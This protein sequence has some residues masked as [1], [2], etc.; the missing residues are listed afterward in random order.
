MSVSCSACCQGASGQRTSGSQLP[1][2]DHPPGSLCPSVAHRNFTPSLEVGGLHG[3]G[4]VCSIPLGPRAVPYPEMGD[5][6]LLRLPGARLT[7]QKCWALPAYPELPER[8]Q[9]PTGSGWRVFSTRLGWS[10]KRSLW[11]DTK[12]AQRSVQE[13]GVGVD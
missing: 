6:C 13:L 8:S 11:G 3:G 4:S 9:C 10:M 12:W 7:C 2:P 1:E 5:R